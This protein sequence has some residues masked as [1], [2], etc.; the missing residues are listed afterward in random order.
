MLYASLAQLENLEQQQI[1]AKYRKLEDYVFADLD[2]TKSKTCCWNT[3]TPAMADIVLDQAKIEQD[4]ATAS[5]MC[6]QP[7]AFRAIKGGD[8]YALWSSHAK[9]MG[10]A[11]DWRAW[12]EDEPCAQKALAEDS[13]SFRGNKD[14]CGTFAVVPDADAGTGANADAGPP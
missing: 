3:T 9:D 13:I 12:S 5:K 2:Y 6:T 11:A 4:K 10:R 1:D 14:Y 8:G 7:T